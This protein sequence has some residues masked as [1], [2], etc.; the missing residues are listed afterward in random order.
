MAA[1]VLDRQG[2]AIVQ[3]ADEIRVEVVGRGL[4]PEGVRWLAVQVAHP[5]S[6][7]IEQVNDLGAS[8]S[9]PAD[10]TPPTP[11]AGSRPGSGARSEAF[12]NW[13]AAKKPKSGMPAP[14]AR[15]SSKSVR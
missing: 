11:R 1:L 10:F 3:L 7:F 13:S 6:N 9:S 2:A 5:A 8:C 4:R 14:V 15:I 12:W